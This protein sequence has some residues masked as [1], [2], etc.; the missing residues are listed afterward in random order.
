MGDSRQVKPGNQNKR[1]KQNRVES[2]DND[3]FAHGKLKHFTP[4]RIRASR[5]GQQPNAPDNDLLNSTGGG[6]VRAST[7]QPPKNPRVES[8]ER[9]DSLQSIE[10]ADYNQILPAVKMRSKRKKRSPSPDNLS[11][12]DNSS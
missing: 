3:D 1:K 11:P 7:K 9:D 10:D 8:V 5:M 12:G 4:G 6:R 2:E